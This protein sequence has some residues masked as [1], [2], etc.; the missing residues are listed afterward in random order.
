MLMTAVIVGLATM[1]VGQVLKK[2]VKI[3]R[4][5]EQHSFVTDFGADAAIGWLTGL[6][7]GASGVTVLFAS[8]FAWLFGMPISA[9]KRKI[10]KDPQF[11]S[12][13]TEYRA[14]AFA[15]A[16]GIGL[17]LKAILLPF[18]WSFKAWQHME[19]ARASNN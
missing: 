1:I 3:L 15:I 13:F 17:L 19:A 8:I 14:F 9:A 16:R 10:A 5:A 11:R 4:K 18:R 2:H 7:F 12:Q 6:A